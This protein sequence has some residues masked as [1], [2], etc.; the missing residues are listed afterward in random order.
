[1][2]HVN[3]VIYPASFFVPLYL[4]LGSI[5]KVIRHKMSNDTFDMV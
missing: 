3:Y 2:S 5:P 1:M 4:F